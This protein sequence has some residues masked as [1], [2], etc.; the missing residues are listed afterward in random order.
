MKHIVLSP[1]PDDAVWSVG[2]RIRWWV[3]RGEATTVVTVFDGPGEVDTDQWRRVAEPATRRSE[4][5]AAIACVG[6]RRV[7]LGLADAAVRADRGVH[8]Y[9]NPMRLFGRIHD[10]DADLPEV[11]AD[12]VAGLLAPHAVV[13]V[14]LAAGRHVD[15]RLVRQA[16]G[17]LAERG[18][19]IRFYEDIPYRLRPAD[20]TGLR[21]GH[22]PVDLAGWLSAA[23]QY[24]SQVAVLFGSVAAMRDALSTRALEYAQG[25]PWPHAGRYWTS[26]ESA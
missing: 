2:G 9:S 7:S 15:H 24:H 8:R 3:S 21:P 6:A 17:L 25:T 18:V 22:E 10:K 14:P 23:E 1:H 13:H 26:T 12:A 20:H 16:A 4:D 11:V 19:P 5:I